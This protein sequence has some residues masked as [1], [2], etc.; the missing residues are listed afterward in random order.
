MATLRVIPQQKL[1]SVALFF[2]LA[3]LII[4]S[5]L[6]FGEWLPP[7]TGGKAVWFYTGLAS[8][9]L[10][11]HL[12]SPYFS[13][14]V[15]AIS[16]AVAAAVALYGAEELAKWSA[17]ENFVFYATLGYYALV[18]LVSFIAIFFRT[19]ANTLGNKTSQTATSLADALGNQRSVFGL[20]ILVALISFPS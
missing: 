18:L 6:A 5:K 10:G 20:T 1:R 15:D 12:V 17:I 11:N 4:A 3:V 8:L 9:L 2:Y 19:S 16:Y 14:P 13:K 7:A